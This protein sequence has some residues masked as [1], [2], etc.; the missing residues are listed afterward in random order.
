MLIDKPTF[1]G[2]YTV[3]KGLSD[4]GSMLKQAQAMGSRMKEMNENLRDVRAV[5]NA[6]GGLVE[7]EVNGLGEMLRLSIDPSLLEKQD[8]ELLEDLVPAAANQ[9]QAKAKEQHAQVLKEL[10]GNMDI[11]GLGDAIQSL[12]EPSTDTPN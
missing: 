3:F 5:G 11:P 6:G 9:A 8:L 1:S 2:A 12:T 10:T 4:L 7:V